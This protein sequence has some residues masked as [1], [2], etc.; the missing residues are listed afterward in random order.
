[1]VCNY[2]EKT[3]TRTYTGL[4][5]ITSYRTKRSFKKFFEIN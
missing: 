1:M 2:A 4:Y 5:A 3:S